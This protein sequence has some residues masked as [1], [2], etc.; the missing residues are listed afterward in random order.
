MI[1]L[2]GFQVAD[3]A[4]GDTTRAHLMSYDIDTGNGSTGG[5]ISNGTVLADGADITNDR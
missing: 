2:F 1:E 4:T 3:E 5:D